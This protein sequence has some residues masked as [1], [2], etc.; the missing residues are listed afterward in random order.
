MQCSM[1]YDVNG[2]EEE[3]GRNDGSGQGTKGCRDSAEE[4]DQL[5]ERSGQPSCV[6][7][8]EGEVPRLKDNVTKH[9]LSPSLKRATVVT[10]ILNSSLQRKDS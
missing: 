7:K 1:K 3:K 9:S 5:E 6:C 10:A 2:C 8:T 4:G